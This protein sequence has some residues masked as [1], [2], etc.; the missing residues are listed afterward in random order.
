MKRRRAVFGIAVACLILISGSCKKGQDDPLISFRSRKAR[1][2]GEWQL[3][4][5]FSVT[6]SQSGNSSASETYEYTKSGFSFRQEI[7]TPAGNI[8]NTDAGAY[9]RKVIFEKNGAFFMEETKAMNTVSYTGLWN[10]TKGV[11]KHKNKQQLAITLTSFTDYDGRLFIYSGKDADFSWTLK[12][13]RNKKMVVEID[14]SWSETVQS[15]TLKS[16]MVFE[17]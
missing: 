3:T 1:V 2:A 12:E 16:E 13:L 15:G 9:S 17:Q 6:T 5:G 14:N 10:F 4:S 8:S 11:G 7:I